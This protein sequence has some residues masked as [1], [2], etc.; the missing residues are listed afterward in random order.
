MAV[1]EKVEELEDRRLEKE[2]ADI[3]DDLS[4]LR[5]DLAD[6]AR[7][8]KET[9]GDYRQTAREEVRRKAGEAQARI[10][11]QVGKARAL[12]EEAVEQMERKIVERPL[13]SLLTAAG[14]GFILARLLEG[15]R[16]N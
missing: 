11:E 14:I 15:G 9:L 5:D 8:L 4:V 2:I 12:G 7:A 3:K 10:G 16:R 6:L 1:K 13:A